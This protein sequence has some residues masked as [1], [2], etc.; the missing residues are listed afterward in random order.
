MPTKLLLR[1]V[2]RVLSTRQGW[3]SIVMI[4]VLTN[5]ARND[6][7]WWMTTLK[8]WNGVPLTTTTVDCQ[9]TTDASMQLW[10]GR[11]LFRQRGSWHLEKISDVQTL[12]FQGATGQKYDTVII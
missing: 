4:V 5:S 10:L 8:G 9:I 1:N 3:D 12:K 2:Y 11:C 6:L 7:L